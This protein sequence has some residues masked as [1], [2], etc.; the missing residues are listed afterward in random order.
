MTT[1][2]GILGG[3]FDPIHRGHLAAAGTALRALKLER[4]LFVPS[5]I[6]PHRP[7]PPLA[8]EFHRFAM[9]TL[10]LSGYSAYEASDIELRMGGLSYTSRT[11]EHLAA[12]GHP[13]SSLFFITGADAFAEIDTWHEYPRLLER[14]HFV[15]VSRPGPSGQTTR[16]TLPSLARYM[17]DAASVNPG[18]LA[19]SPLPSILLVSASTPDVS[20]TRIRQII[21]RKG[22][23]TDAVPA[24]VA[25]HIARHGLYQQRMRRRGVTAGGRARTVER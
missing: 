16:D 9:V 11:L 15:V 8:S 2:T 7:T 6:P 20:S 14:A 21:E 3:T 23:L 18:A 12:Q 22:R 13:P 25:D 1:R 17:R 10:A 19:R 5:S 24:A 4:V